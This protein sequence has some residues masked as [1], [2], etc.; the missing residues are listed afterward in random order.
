M[1]QHPELLQEEVEERVGFVTVR[2]EPIPPYFR[3]EPP[4]PTILVPNA[5]PA[6]ASK[7]KG[8]A[9]ASP[10]PHD[11]RGH[12]RHLKKGDRTVWV[13]PCRINTLIPH[14]TRTREFYE[15]RLP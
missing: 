4:K 11:R 14:L 9:H 1:K 2:F 7:P 13:K 15:V 5:A 12:P 3:I 6:V 10:K 8:G